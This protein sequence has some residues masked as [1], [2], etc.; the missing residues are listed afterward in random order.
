MDVAVGILYI[1][2]LLFVSIHSYGLDTIKPC[3]NELQH[4]TQVWGPLF[5]INN[6]IP[7]PTQALHLN[8]ESTG[9][10]SACSINVFDFVKNVGSLDGMETIYFTF[11]CKQEQTVIFTNI[12]NAKLYL[13]KF[14]IVG[15]LQ[16]ISCGVV[17]NQ[18]EFLMEMTRMRVAL[19]YNVKYNEGM[20]AVTELDNESSDCTGMNYLKSLVVHNVSS[21]SEFM[22]DL[23]H[24]NTSFPSVAEITFSNLSMSNLSDEIH[25]LY[26]NIQSIDIQNNNLHV[27]PKFHL[28]QDNIPLPD[29]LFRSDEAQAHYADAFHIVIERNMFRRVIN[30]SKNKILS[31]LPFTFEGSLHIIDLDNNLI[32][33]IHKTAFWMVK[34]LQVLSMKNNEIVR[35]PELLLAN[36]TELR[37]IDLSNN[38]I[39][40]LLPK[41]FVLASK[42]HFIDLSRNSIQSLPDSLFELNANLNILRMDFNDIVEIPEKLLTTSNSPLS[43]L[44]VMSNKILKLPKLIFYCRDL[45]RIRLNNNRIFWKDL[46]SVARHI[47][48]LKFKNE[49][50]LS[51]SNIGRSKLISNLRM[52][53]LSNNSIESLSVE[54]DDNGTNIIF[55]SLLLSNFD[56]ILADNPLRCDCRVMSFINM[57]KKLIVDGQLSEDLALVERL[58]CSQP[59]ELNGFRVFEMQTQQ[60]R[61]YCEDHKV[62]C[63]KFCRCF[64]RLITR[65]IIVD[66]SENKL[67]SVSIYMPS[68]II[69]LR[70]ARNKIT[71]LPITTYLQNITYLDLSENELTKIENI[72]FTVMKKL[73]YLDVSYNLLKSLPESL[74]YLPLSVLKISHNPFRCDCNMKWMK[75][76]FAKE[77]EV[78]HD[79]KDTSCLTE[80]SGTLISH[81]DKSK[82]VCR[83][84]K[85]IKEYVWI[86]ITIPIALIVVIVVI[87][88]Y[89][90]TIRVLLFY[91]LG[92]DCS[93]RLSNTDYLFDILLVYPDYMAHFVKSE[94][95][96]IIQDYQHAKTIDMWKDMYAGHSIQDNLNYFAT[97]SKKL[98]YIIDPENTGQINEFLE[99][100]W[101]T[102]SSFIRGG[103]TSD[104][105]LLLK[106]KNLRSISHA[107][108]RKFAKRGTTVVYEA[109]LFSHTLVYNLS[110][111]KN[112]PKQEERSV[113]YTVPCSLRNDTKMICDTTQVLLFIAYKDEDI[114]IVTRRILPIMNTA[115]LS[116]T[117]KETFHPGRHLLESVHLAIEQNKHTLILFTPNS[118]NDEELGH[119]FK[120]AFHRSVQGHTNHLIVLTSGLIHLKS[121]QDEYIHSYLKAYDVINVDDEIN[122]ETKL[123]KAIDMFVL[124]K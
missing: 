11:S 100:T 9:A 13:L 62:I 77:L 103:R 61:L 15:Y 37:F 68:N 120:L 74:Q 25:N 67:T 47:D 14:S 46:S 73:R 122:C 19:F 34:D 118:V 82:F 92:C 30:L 27:V 21:S 124:K 94:V 31:I 38:R 22:R 36:Q 44:S 51:A 72:V 79:W 56:I 23:H 78:A 102:C 17:P 43:E 55:I 18:I 65:A 119:I 87:I 104:V 91:Y 12:F 76:W 8:I 89:R 123:C 71:T 105:I 32:S 70:L 111:Q 117:T 40:Y 121:V 5:L 6:T 59:E 99:L 2:A 84:L 58:K 41:T 97:H 20:A 107:D 109:R 80:D 106:S 39:K 69:E 108:I 95:L 42:L 110:L 24:C 50:D 98:L 113:I 83:K 49:V 86:Y 116:F 101:D 115:H 114:E 64:R 52:L 4:H 85:T 81:V 54:N 57:V 88:V 112:L 35:F 10:N 28:S 33:S 1:S 53:D 90:K 93:C 7:V 75:S 66:C 63:P 26:P 60:D 3:K 96:Q 45:R 29:D 16:I 48:L